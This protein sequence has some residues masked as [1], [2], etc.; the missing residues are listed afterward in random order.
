MHFSPGM[1]W[2]VVCTFSLI[3]EIE[4]LQQPN[5]IKQD[6]AGNIVKIE[7]E[8]ENSR[9]MVQVQP[10]QPQQSKPGNTQMNSGTKLILIHQPN[11]QLLAVPASQ[12]SGN[13][14]SVVKIPPTNDKD[15]QIFS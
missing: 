1:S 13:G 7:K 11:G 2:A 14:S 8:A 12:L 3:K 6:S 9:V 4:K 10:Q 15:L 5:E